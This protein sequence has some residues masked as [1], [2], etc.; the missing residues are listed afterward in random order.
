MKMNQ[1]DGLKKHPA[2]NARLTYK[3]K[4]ANVYVSA[5]GFH[6]IDYLDPVAEISPEIDA[7]QLTDQESAY[8][9]TQLQANLK[10]FQN[11]ADILSKHLPLQNANVLDI[12]CGG[13]L[14]L[15]LLK[16]AGA[17]VIGIE[18]SDSRAQYAKT[19]HGL[20]INKHPIENEFWQKGYADHFDAVTLWDVIEHVNYPFEALQSAAN[21]LKQGGLLLIDT[22]CRDSFYHQFGAFTY[23]LTSGKFPTFL[24]AMYSSH[25]FG[26][27]QIFS[28][29]EMKNLFESVGLEVIDLHKFHELSFPYEF[30]LKKLFKSEAIVRLLLP[31][32]RIFFKIFKIQNKMLVVGR[33]R[34]DYGSR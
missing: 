30:Y 32:V 15:S 34:F 18:L 6:F 16:Q 5:E 7:S 17:E 11:Q 24:N 12:G 28:T 1:I 4:N 13:G 27:K 26:H 8:I 31:A 10:K 3:L 33:K 21:V 25:L 29:A 14:F 9:E 2:Q 20:E 22:P 19:K 23:R